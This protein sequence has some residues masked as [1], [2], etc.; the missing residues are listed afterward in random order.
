MRFSPESF[1][2]LF[3]RL[4]ET[5]Q[6]APCSVIER[7]TRQVGELFGGNSETGRHLPGH[8][9]AL[10]SGATRD[11]GVEEVE[12]D[13]PRAGQDPHPPESLGAR[14]TSTRR[15]VDNRIAS[16]RVLSS[17]LRRTSSACERREG[18]T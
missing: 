3:D 16:S 1:R 5:A 9:V 13:G 2:Q 7:V 8:L 11:E 14:G 12:D 18:S 4:G 10:F 15:P 6:T 17:A